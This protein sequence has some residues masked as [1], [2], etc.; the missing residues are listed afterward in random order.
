MRVGALVPG[1]VAPDIAA[2]LTKQRETFVLRVTLEEQQSAL[3]SL[4]HSDGPTVVAAIC[5]H[6][7]AT[8]QQVAGRD[9]VEARV[10]ERQSR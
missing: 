5:Q 1:Q 3:A 9:F 7:V 4:A 10:W 2:V 8:F 6:P